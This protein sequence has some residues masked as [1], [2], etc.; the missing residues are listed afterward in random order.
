MAGQFR[1]QFAIVVAALLGLLA[2]ALGAHAEE[3]KLLGQARKDLQDKRY[4]EAINEYTR[5]IQSHPDAEPAWQE[6]GLCKVWS[7]H[8]QEGLKDLTRAIEL[9]PTNW[10][11]Y[12]H[13][14]NT[15]IMLENFSAA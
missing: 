4:A 14:C 1:R 12:V 8:K 7:D 9:S 2:F 15:Y 13:R 10:S 3:D 6:R 5:Y 11:N